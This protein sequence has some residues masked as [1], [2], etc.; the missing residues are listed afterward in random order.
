[1]TRRDIVG[2]V[3]FSDME[4]LVWTPHEVVDVDGPRAMLRA[5][6]EQ[7]DVREFCAN[8]GSARHLTAAC[9]VGCG[10]GR[11]TPVLTEFAERVVGFEREAA[12]LSIASALQPTVQFCEIDQLQRLPADRSS[13]DLALVFTVLQH[14]PEPEVRDVIDE[15]R[16]IVKPS[17][18]VLLCEETDAALEAGDRSAAHLGYTCGRPV[19]TY[20]EW[21]AP[22]RLVASKRR[23]IEPGYPRPD[24]GTYMLFSGPARD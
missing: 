2:D 1:L 19:A 3:C 14:V 21:L 9:D 16:R 13:F 6:L 15:L 10:F 5:Y 23:T 17:G 12:L 22:W 11:L 24:V 8:A 18:H 20:Q 4:R 7:R